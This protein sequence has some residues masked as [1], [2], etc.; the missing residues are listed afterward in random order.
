MKTVRSKLVAKVTYYVLWQGMHDSCNREIEMADAGLSRAALRAAVVKQARLMLKRES[1]LRRHTVGFWFSVTRI[2][3]IATRDGVYTR[4]KEVL[5]KGAHNW[6]GARFVRDQ[7]KRI[8]R[9]RF[10]SHTFP[11]SRNVFLP[12]I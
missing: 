6:I 8:I 1:D 11:G 2:K 12:R 9:T 10:G 3:S 4:R 7:G 5:K